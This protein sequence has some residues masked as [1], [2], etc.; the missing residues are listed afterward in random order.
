M[1]MFS[2]SG[3][4]LH[5][6][7]IKAASGEKAPSLTSADLGLIG[8]LMLLRKVHEVMEMAWE[9]HKEGRIELKNQADRKHEIDELE[10]Q[11]KLAEARSDLFKG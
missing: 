10:A 11:S 6:E 9:A 5:A 1:C 2:I 8:R 3:I 4:A 7:L